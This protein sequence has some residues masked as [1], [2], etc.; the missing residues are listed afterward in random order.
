[1]PEKKMWH[2]VAYD[3]RDP[4]RLLKVAKHLKGYGVRL[5]YSLFRCRLSERQR[6]RLQW[7]LSLLLKP[8]DDLLIVGLCSHCSE[9]LRKKGGNM[10]WEPEFSLFEIL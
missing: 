2:L 8:E 3:V 7:E 9:R 1:M 10:D 6:E 4:K 5:Q